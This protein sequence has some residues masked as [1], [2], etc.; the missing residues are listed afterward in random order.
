MSR[1]NTSSN[2][3]HPDTAEIRE[4]I[5]AVSPLLIDHGNAV[6]P[7]LP[8]WHHTRK[9]YHWLVA[10]LLLR[11]MTRTAAEKA[12]DDLVGDFSTW[13]R[14]RSASREEIK[15]RVSWIGLGN[16]RSNQ[17]KQ[18]AETI[19]EDHDKSPPKDRV[20]LMRLPGVGEYTADALMLYAFASPRFPIDGGIQRVSRRI[21]GLPIPKETRHTDPYKDPI[22]EEVA[23]FVTTEHTAKEITSMHRG[24]LSI[25]WSLCR[26]QNPK[27]QSCPL[28][29]ECS[30]SQI[31]I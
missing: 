1:C 24:I 28:R 19:V 11:R 13:T 23:D 16:Q 3:D 27:C 12:F 15:N 6:A 25:S 29:S 22:V 10:E 20:G 30:S 2:S 7:D 5:E 21:L 9:P 8:R 17:L 31:P 4:R 26:K 14:L 18:L